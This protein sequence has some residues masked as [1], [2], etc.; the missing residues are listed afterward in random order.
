MLQSSLNR[1]KKTE[2][3]F[4]K[5]FLNN[6]SSLVF[7]VTEK[8]NLVPRKS[9]S[10]T[11]FT[12]KTIGQNC[13]NCYFQMPRQSSFGIAAAAERCGFNCSF[14]TDGAC[15]FYPNH[16]HRRHTNCP[17]LLMRI[18]LVALYL[19]TQQ[20]E[21]MARLLLSIFVHLQVSNHPIYQLA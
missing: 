18:L 9:W 7:L 12:E 1:Q 13:K 8:F 2:V 6:F 17:G 3:R 19:P 21:Q 16:C 14:D 4:V 10:H 11:N 5:S 15:Y 20:C